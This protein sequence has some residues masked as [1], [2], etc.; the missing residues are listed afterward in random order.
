METYT[1]KKQKN[2]KK[3]KETKTKEDTI[4]ISTQKDLSEGIGHDTSRKLVAALV[5]PAT[6]LDASW[7]LYFASLVPWS[8]TIFLYSLPHPMRPLL[9]HF[10]L[11][12]SVDANIEGLQ[13]RRVSSGNDS[14]CKLVLSAQHF[15]LASDMGSMRVH[16]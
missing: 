14:Q 16:N 11:E 13:H 6:Q 2:T 7:R 10:G 8:A 9:P 4:L 1:R 15:H 3:Q 12:R 5:D